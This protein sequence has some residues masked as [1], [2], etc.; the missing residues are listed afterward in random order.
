MFRF[1]LIEITSPH[2]VTH[3]VPNIFHA[4][5]SPLLFMSRPTQSCPSCHI[6]IMFFMSSPVPHKKGKENR[7]EEDR[8]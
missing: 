7:K 6:I 4:M 8:K 3:K 1:M 5:A 2:I